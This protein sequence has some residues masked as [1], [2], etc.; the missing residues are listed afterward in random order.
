M[1]NSQVS[2]S[3][4]MFLIEAFIDNSGNKVFIVYGYG[5]K[6]TFAA[7]LFFKSI[8]CPNMSSY[9]NA[10]YVYRWTDSN[11]DGFVDLNEIDMTPVASG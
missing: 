10:Y 4:D 2:N 7:G 9:S 8:I 1:S 5:W 6:G 11:G 3:Q